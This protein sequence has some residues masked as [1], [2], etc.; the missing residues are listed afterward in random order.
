M[1]I[2]SMEQGGATYFLLAIHA[3]TSMSY[4]VSLS[5]TIKVQ[6][7]KIRDFEGEDVLKAVSFLRGSL[8]RLAMCKQMPPNMIHQVLKIFGTSSNYKFNGFFNTWYNTLEQRSMTGG[9]SMESL[10]KVK[11]ILTMAS[12]QYR[13]MTEEGT[14]AVRKKQGASFTT[15]VGA[16]NGNAAPLDRTNGGP[17]SVGSPGSVDIPKWKKAPAPG[18]PSERLFK[19]KPKYCCDTCARWVRHS[20]AEHV[21]RPASIAPSSHL[22]KQCN[23]VVVENAAAPAPEASAPQSQVG[24]ILRRTGL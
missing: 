5:L 4:A 11:T 14:W 8:Q 3:T 23:S 7:M 15:S 19:G 16:L 9:V 12:P 10:V 24:S 1:T 18:E 22:D 13:A 6:G 17:G 20:S 2:P 21:T